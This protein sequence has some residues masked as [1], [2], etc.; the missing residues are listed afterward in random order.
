MR[1]LILIH[2]EAEAEVRAA[3]P[4]ARAVL[5]DPVFRKE[6]SFDERTRDFVAM[7]HAQVD[8]E[9]R[10]N[11]RV[12]MTVATQCEAR[13]FALWLGELPAE[14]KPWVVVCFQSDRWNRWGA[15]EHARQMDEFR[16]LA[17]DLAALVPAD[18][19]RL[20]FCSPTQGLTTELAG[21]LRQPVAVA[22]M[23][24]DYD[25][26]ETLAASRPER[27]DRPPRVAVVGGAREEKGSHKV[28][29]V[30]RACRAS[31][32]ALDFVVQLANEGLS[33]RDWEDLAGVATEPGVTV[34]HGALERHR[35]LR[36]L[37]DSD[38][39][40]LPYDRLPYRQRGSGILAEAV[41]AG[42]PVIVPD[43]TWAAEQV[44]EGKAAGVA[45]AGD[46]PESIAA[47]LGRCA[48]EIEPLRARAR[49]CAPAWM[50]S[51]SLQ[52][53]LDWMEGEIAE[54]TTD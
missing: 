39:L 22:P 40:L 17:A 25:G 10:L 46:G 49:A 53:F 30:V 26:M 4:E 5:H 37:A 38:V 2:R 45:Y 23:A 16:T 24:M 13:A 27:L 41:A 21:L 36:L 43:G 3:L 7:L 54:R 18:Q 42:M 48:A 33:P 14:R 19:R 15:E 47:A 35:Y 12:L 9:V 6:W 1:P 8:P 11:D 31:G 28:R 34:V 44:D 51:Q 50:R 32:T 52:A 29:P 20:L